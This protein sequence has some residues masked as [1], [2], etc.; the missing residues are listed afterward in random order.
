[1]KRL[2]RPVGLYEMKLLLDLELKA[3][4]PRLPEQPIFYPVLNKAYADQI[5]SEWNTKDKFSGY[6]GFV[7]EFDVSSPFID[8]YEE[9][10]VGAGNHK[11]LW[12]PAEQL[13]EMNENIQ[14]TIRLVDVFYGGN[15]AGLTPELIAF[16]D[17]NIT[18][19]FKVWQEI[20]DNDPAEF[21]CRIREQ[22]KPIFVNFKYW[23]DASHERSGIGKESKDETLSRMKKVWYEH[24]PD[25]SLFEGN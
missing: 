14:G 5:A 11:E 2:Y 19:Q 13:Q 7:T 15:Y 6:A 16:E 17:K 12:I 21:S 8:R 23:A 4:P 20:S 3:F 10:I 22:W 18:D 25:L 1:M 24:F 9:Q